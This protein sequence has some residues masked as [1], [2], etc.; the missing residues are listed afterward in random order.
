[1]RKTMPSVVGRL[2]IVE[3]ATRRTIGR[4]GVAV[5]DEQH[6]DVARVVELPAAEL[7]HADHRQPRLGARRGR[8]RRRGRPRRARRARAR[9]RGGRPAR[10][11]RGPRCAAAPAASSGAA[12]PVRPRGRRRTRRRNAGSR[13]RSAPA[14]SR[15]RRAAGRA[16]RDR[17]SPR[18]TAI[19]TR[20]RPPPAQTR[21]RSSAASS[22]ASWGCSS[23]RRVSTARARPGSADCSIASTSAGAASTVG[24]TVPVCR[25]GTHGDLGAT[26]RILVACRACASRLAQLD[27]VVGDLEGN[28]ER[29]LDAYEQGA[30][31]GCDLIA[32][33]ELSITGYPPEDL[34]LRPAFVAQA[35]EAWRRWRPGPAGRRRWSASRWRSATSPTPPRCAPTARCRASTA[36]TLLPNYA[37][38]DE[39]R[40]FAAVHRRRSAVRHRRRARRG[41]DLRGR[42][43]PDRADQHAGRGR[44]RARRQHQR[45]RRTTRAG[46]RERETML[47]T[48]AADASVPIVYVNLV[49]GQDELVFDGGSMVF[50]EAG[51]ARRPRRP[52]RR[53]PARR[54]SRRAAHLPQAPARPP[55]P[56]VVAGAARGQ[57]HRGP[58]RRA[59]LAAA[60]RTRAP[61]RA[62]GLRGA[63][64]R[65]ARLRRA[66]T[67]SPT[68][69]SAC[70]AASTRRWWRSIAADALGPERVHR[71]AHAVAL[72]ERGQRHRRRRCSPTTSASATL[73]VPI[74][75]AH[76]AF[77]DMLAEPF[78]GTGGRASPRRT[79]R[80]A[81]AAR[82]S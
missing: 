47:A 77:L 68:C 32:F 31:A 18:S 46:S 61:A 37:V 40:Y 8:R 74:E 23:T 44:G 14:R 5:V 36:S 3:H 9:R 59:R 67:A 15:R 28:V 55:R 53:G 29:I 1:M 12:Q 54:R 73:T 35:Q 65:H 25:M 62:G 76:A 24:V 71:R 58:H 17:R 39:Q 4:A 50:D 60:A 16:A 26:R 41:H 2:M 56:A 82:S 13:R 79:S 38:F 52:V 49:G 66:R 43:E 22:S 7:A 69:S 70:R 45:A 42:V 72:L 64:A 80:P 10:G 75:A 34:L 19:A 33:P 78:A 30:D 11:G 81:S 27:L 20:P 51:P 6:V 21:R 63:R 57:G 48:R